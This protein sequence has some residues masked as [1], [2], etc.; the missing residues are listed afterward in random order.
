MSTLTKRILSALV[1]APVALGAVWLGGIWYCLFVTIVGCLMAWEWTGLTEGNPWSVRSAVLAAVVIG[2]GIAA[3]AGSPGDLGIGLVA[4]AVLCAGLA[5][6]GKRNHFWAVLAV[7]YICL[8]I[9]FLIILRNDAAFGL[10]AIIWLF[11]V[12]WATDIFAY[13]AGR[14]FG[15]P[16]LAPRASPNKTWAGLFGGIAGASIV[17][18]VVAILLK[19]D[20]MV[21]LALLS[22]ML[23]VIAQIGDIAESAMKRHFDV[24]D[25][26]NLIPGHGGV[27]DRVDGV[28]T[29]V[30]LAGAIGWY[31]GGMDEAARG[32]LIW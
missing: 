12:V 27:M 19:L 31:R 13:F 18:A 23:A 1:M 15:G 5:Q 11:L 7:P 14:T 26:S 22:G 32:I 6:I 2:I 21:V 30:A 3:Y 10:A 29:V 20:S 8:P 16:K 17:G 9:A 4:G 25:S 24:K 28:V